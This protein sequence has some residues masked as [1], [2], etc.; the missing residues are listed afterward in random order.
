MK[1]M[2]CDIHIIVER[3]NMDDRTWH[4]TEE[5]G[6]DDRNYD[7][8]NV[9]AGVRADTAEEMAEWPN[10]DGKWNP[11]FCFSGRERKPIA[12]PRGVPAD[13]SLEAR[14]F[15]AEEG[16]HSTS[17]ATAQEVLYY[18][19][20]TEIGQ[21]GWVD[22]D[23]WLALRTGTRPKEWSQGI[24]GG[25]IVNLT[26][27]MMETRVDAMGEEERKNTYARASWKR[28]PH[29]KHF[30]A[31]MEGLVK[32]AQADDPRRGGDDVRLVFTFD[33]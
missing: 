19:W 1:N 17:H 29:C 30:V 21:S 32:S 16:G 4:A 13:A 6:G 2:G 27:A 22:G 28:A 8:F 10:D 31:W 25:R 12:E 5:S 26:A 3:R 7:V 11:K 24:G 18:P 15:I 9:L 20:D 14:E 23:Q 33:S